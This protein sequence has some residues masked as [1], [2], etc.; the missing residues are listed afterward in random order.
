MQEVGR[1]GPSAGGAIP[2]PTTES[3]PIPCSGSGRTAYKYFT[4]RAH[5]KE[6]CGIFQII[7]EWLKNI[8]ILGKYYKRL[9]N[10][11]QILFMI[12]KVGAG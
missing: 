7:T 2:S 6:S 9:N 3:E 4:L 12:D 1:T 8:A 11:E 5:G 10:S